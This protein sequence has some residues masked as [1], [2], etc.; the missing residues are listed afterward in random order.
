[1]H[2]GR[3]ARKVSS[4]QSVNSNSNGSSYTQDIASH[5]P[6]D[7]RG[8]V[9][10]FGDEYWSKWYTSTGTMPAN[11]YMD[12]QSHYIKLMP[13]IEDEIASQIENDGCAW[14]VVPKEDEPI[15]D[16]VNAV[17]VSHYDIEYTNEK[18]VLYNR[19]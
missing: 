3:V 2:I 19:V 17:I 8:S 13:E 5:I 10:C 11:K 4:V 14:I 12:W 7:E 6:E 15:S 16:K 18:Y 1:M 9:Y